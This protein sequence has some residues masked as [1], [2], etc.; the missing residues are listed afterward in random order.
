MISKVYLD[1]FLILLV[2]FGVNALWCWQCEGPSC[3]VYPDYPD[4]DGWKKVECTGS[5]VY[6]SGR[7]K[8]PDQKPG[9]D[10]WIHA[11]YYCSPERMITTSDW[12]L[13]ESVIFLCVIVNLKL[14][15]SLFKQKIFHILST[16]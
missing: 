4:R 16:L 10:T 9:I 15:H 8:R 2:D 3:G 1:L 13:C 7:P 5:C 6:E 11:K 14:P 12:G